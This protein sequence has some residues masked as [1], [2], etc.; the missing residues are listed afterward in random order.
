MFRITLI[1]LS[2]L[3]ACSVPSWAGGAAARSRT[4]RQQQVVQQQ[5]TIQQKQIIQQQIAQKQLMLQKQKQALLEYQ[6][7][8]QKQISGEIEIQAQYQRP[9]A[10]APVVQDVVE[11]R[12]L[13]EAFETSSE[14]WALIIDQVSKEMIVA[15]YIGL[16]RQK[17]ITLR[18]LPPH[19]AG[20][21]DSMS[22]GNPSLL[23]KPFAEILQILAILEYDFDNGQNKDAMALKILGQAGFAENK[24]RLG[25]K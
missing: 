11:M 22:E 12:Q 6:A 18:K 16:F 24:K 19:Y 1:I 4:M 17:G 7:Q 3:A 2:L 8:Q 5:Q 25:L 14:A 13:W 10:A 15:H 20:L 9:Y 23:R 21:I